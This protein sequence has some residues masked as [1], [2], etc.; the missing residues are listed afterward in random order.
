M[1]GRNF[2]VHTNFK[3]PYLS[4]NSLKKTQFKEDN[5]LNPSFLISCS[6]SIIL[7]VLR[8]DSECVIQSAS[9]V[10]TVIRVCNVNSHIIGQAVYI[11]E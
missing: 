9:V 6:S 4:L 3:A 5:V 11:I 10:I 8:R 1:Q 2:V 7:I